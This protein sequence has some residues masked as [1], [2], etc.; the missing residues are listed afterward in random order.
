MS[1]SHSSFF[2][3]LNIPTKINKGTVEI[4]TPVELIKKG[5]KVGSSES[6]L[7]AKLGIR[8]FSYGLQVTS[9]YEDGS[10]F[11]PEVLDLSEEDL[12][13]KF[14]TGVSMVASLSLA[15]SYPTLAAVPHM[16]IN[17]YKN[18]LAVAVETDYS[19]PHADKIKEYLKVVCVSL[20]HVNYF[21]QFKSMYKSTS[22]NHHAYLR[23]CLLQVFKLTC[24]STTTPTVYD[25]I[26]F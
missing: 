11:S 18:V 26:M 5:E 20:C 23:I 24:L 12:I 1:V 8:P 15:L 3:V 4:I 2:Q 13:E 7:L 17:G 10:V 9:V 25:Q 6:A 14:A 19:Y 16:F 21:E 22:F